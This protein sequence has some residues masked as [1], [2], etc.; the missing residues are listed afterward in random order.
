MEAFLQL[1]Q[2]QLEFMETVGAPGSRYTIQGN[3]IFY[4]LQPLASKKIVTP[5]QSM[6]HANW[7][8][9]LSM[10]LCVL[11]HILTWYAKGAESVKGQDLE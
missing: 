6:S 4:P 3:S 2:L 9:A 8:T 5:S 1:V 11:R 10:L 7:N